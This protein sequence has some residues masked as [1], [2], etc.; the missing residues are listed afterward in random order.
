MTIYLMNLDI[1][2]SRP[3]ILA[4]RNVAI[5]ATDIMPFTL[6]GIATRISL[7]IELG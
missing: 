3:Q 4:E 7:A 6:K 2:I 5:K 1:A